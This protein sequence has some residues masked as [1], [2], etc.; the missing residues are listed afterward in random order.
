MSTKT[1]LKQLGKNAPAKKVLKQI[2]A[3]QGLGRFQESKP[4]CERLIGLGFNN[5]DFLHVYGLT[6]RGCGDLKGALVA[7]HSAHQQKPDDVRIINSM[8]AIFLQMED[9][10][11]A[12]ELFKRTTNMEQRYYEGWLNLGIALKQAERY[13]A[14]DIALTCAHRLDPARVE[15][16]LNLVDILIE[17]RVYKRAEEFMDKLLEKQTTIT[18]RLQLKR[19]HIAARLQ[20]LSYIKFHREAVDRESFSQDEKA[21]LDNIWV[22]CLEIEG[23]H[24]EAIAV[25]EPWME[26]ETVHK[27]QLQTQLGLFYSIVGRMD[28]AIAVHE[29]LLRAHPDHVA[30]R[31]N[32]AG[33]QFRTGQLSEGFANYEARWQWKELSTHRRRFDAPRWDGQPLEGKKLLVW[34]E[35]GIGDE[36]R[37]ASLLPDLKDLGGSVTFECTPKLAPLFAHAFPWAT[38]RNEGPLECRGVDDYAAFD[39]QIPVGSLAKLFRPSLEA[40]RNKQV[41]W[42]RRFPEAEDKVRAQLDLDGE[43]LLVGIC[44][45]SANRAASRNRYYVG[46]EHLAPLKN[47]QG[48][49]WLNVQYDATADEIDTIRKLGVTLHHYT[50]VNQKDDL[51]TACALLGACDIV[52][53]APVS[54]ADLTGGLGVPTALFIQEDSPVFLGT[55]HVPW[56]PAAKPFMIRQNGGEEV[57]RKIASEWPALTDWAK[58]SPGAREHRGAPGSRPTPGAVRLDLEYDHPVA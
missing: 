19:L 57:I 34:R 4:L 22:H 35:Q 48:I 49:R 23:R 44:W 37:Y 21:E 52:I 18:P 55:D 3:L 26:R 58:R 39:F 10:E 7:I 40:F 14:A 17:L 6:L 32:L 29:D 54:V 15:P 53:S 46:I 13:Q 30:G 25:L 12:I 50:N 1:A 11:T 24:A 27:T 8:G 47:L 31:Y 28:E 51:V 2:Q 36:V 56:F 16:M 38:I 42:I 41:P 43:E 9:V 20:D 33:L 5:P 45:R